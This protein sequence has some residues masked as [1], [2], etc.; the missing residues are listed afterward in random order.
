MSSQMLT[1]LLQIAFNTAQDDVTLQKAISGFHQ[2]AMLS[3]HFELYDVFDSIVV[4]LATMTGLLDMSGH[5]NSLPDPIVDVAGEKYVISSL[6][7]RFGRNYKAQLAAVVAFT[8][9]TRHGNSLRNGWTKVTRGERRCMEKD[10]VTSTAYP[11][12]IDSTS[13]S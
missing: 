13:D 5:S 6:A 3:A 12:F 1:Q 4:N 11:S 8:I 10:K 7:V 2:C 9:V